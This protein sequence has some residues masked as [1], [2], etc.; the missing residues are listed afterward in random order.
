MAGIMRQIIPS[1]STFFPTGKSLLEGLWGEGTL[2]PG[3]TTFYKAWTEEGTPAEPAGGRFKGFYMRGGF[4]AVPYRYE[5]SVDFR[6]PDNT[7]DTHF[8]SVWRA[9]PDAAA[10]IEEDMSLVWE[11][12][13]EKYKALGIPENITVYRAYFYAG[14]RP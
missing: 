14:A 10:T 11:A 13:A 6:R 1:L 4:F 9:T 2:Q 8:F 5:Y 3:R 12:K 7:I